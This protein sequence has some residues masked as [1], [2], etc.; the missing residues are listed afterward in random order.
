MAPATSPWK[1][2]HRM[3]AGSPAPS[4]TPSLQVRARRRRAFDSFAAGRTRCGFWHGPT[5]NGP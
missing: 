3:S 1:D 5:E 4:N 2:K